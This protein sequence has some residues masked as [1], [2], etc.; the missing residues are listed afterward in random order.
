LVEL[1]AT[2]S[3]LRNEGEGA[4]L[5]PAAG[6]ADLEALAERSTAAG[7]AV[8]IDRTGDVRPLPPRV[9]LAGYRV[10]Q[11]AVTNVRRHSGASHARIELGYG[12]AELRVTVVDDG[13]GRAADSPDGQGIIGMRE[14][15]SALGGALDV[16]PG[17]T[18]GYAVRATIPLT[19]AAATR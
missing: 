19:D 1:R 8:E 5:A 14:R 2:V 12:D 18:R 16:G 3:A 11:E 7:L 10:V 15:I 9:E 6:L 17:P 13:Q 4:P